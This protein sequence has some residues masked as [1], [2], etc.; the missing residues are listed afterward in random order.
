MEVGLKTLIGDGDLSLGAMHAGEAQQWIC[1]GP[2]RGSS[3]LC[4]YLLKCHLDHGYHH[5]IVEGD[6][7]SLIQLLKS[8]SAQYN[9]S[10]FFY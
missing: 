9:S 6:S 3:L 5:V 4:L 10:S 8:P 2:S 7:L 1:R